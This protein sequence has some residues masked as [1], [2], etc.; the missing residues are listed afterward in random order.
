MFGS[1]QTDWNG[2]R[3]DAAPTTCTYVGMKL[4]FARQF[5]CVVVYFECILTHST[6]HRRIALCT[7]HHHIA[8][9]PRE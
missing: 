7:P 1:A 9:Q 8:T 5:L 3:A 6:L 2:D 4:M